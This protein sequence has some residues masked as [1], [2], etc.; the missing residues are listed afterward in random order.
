M[1]KT[2]VAEIPTS[3]HKPIDI[4]PQKSRLTWKHAF[5]IIGV[6]IFI[7]VGRY[8]LLT[9][10]SASIVQPLSINEA[11]LTVIV[12][13]TPTPDPFAELTIPYLREREYQSSLIVQNQV[14]E[15]ASYTSFLAAY[16]SDGLTIN[17]L[18][19]QPKGEMPQGGWPAIVFVHGYIPPQQY[20]T[21]ENYNSYVDYL[22]KNG[23]VVFKIDLRGHN[24]SEGE[25]SGGY[26]SGDYVIDTLNARA[27]LQSTSFINPQKIGLWGH[28]MAGNIV[29][30]AFVAKQD[31]AA[32]VIWAGAVYTYSDFSDYSI[33]DNSYQ[34]P[35]PDSSQ[36]KKRELLWELHGNFDPNDSFWQQV[37]GTNYL[38]G[39][40]GALQMNHAVDDGVVSVEYSRNLMRILD[41]T[42]IAHELEEYPSG[43]HNLTG[44]AFSQAMQNTVEFFKAYLK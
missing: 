24:Q 12:S 3:P 16:D 19:T 33:E 25:P 11:Q 7:L 38:E 26:Y 4:P 6:I 8:L 22:A 21:T 1:E 10:N 41:K 43:G 20:R 37:P 39:V 44:A 18:L 40:S 29:F 17:G 34:P 9:N 35:R 27:A 13:P 36:A 28:S 42:T 31:V 15:T 14:A 2:P 32:I 5:L 30:R 23:F